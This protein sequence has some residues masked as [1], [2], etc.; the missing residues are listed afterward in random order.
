[1]MKCQD[2]ASCPLCPNKYS[3]NTAVP[4]TLFLP[5]PPSRDWE[6]QSHGRMGGGCR[7]L[8]PPAASATAPFSLPTG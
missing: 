8:G 4:S 5:P 2:T 1:V 3:P 6:T 7:H